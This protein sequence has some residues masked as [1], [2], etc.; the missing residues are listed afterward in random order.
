MVIRSGRVTDPPLRETEYGI[1]HSLA[2]WIYVSA[3]GHCAGGLRIGERRGHL[4]AI[5]GNERQ[6]DLGRRFDRIWVGDDR[7]GAFRQK[8]QTEHCR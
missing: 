4:R 8:N 6:F 3:S 1:G 5:A 2:Y 7:A